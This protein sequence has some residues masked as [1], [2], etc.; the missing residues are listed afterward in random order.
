MSQLASV[1]YSED[2]GPLAKPAPIPYINIAA[3]SASGWRS[4]SPRD[5]N[6]ERDVEGFEGEG[7]QDMGGRT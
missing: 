5:D 6:T 7:S 2:D 1:Q 3:D 4:P